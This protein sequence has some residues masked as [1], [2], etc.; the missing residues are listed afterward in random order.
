MKETGVNRQKNAAV[1]VQL[2][3]ERKLFG[4]GEECLG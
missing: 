3:G 4:K 2:E 1:S